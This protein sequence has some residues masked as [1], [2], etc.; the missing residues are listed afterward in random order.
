VNVKVMEGDAPDPKACSLIG[1]CYIYDLPEGL[2]KGAPIEVTYAF[3]TSGRVKV[4]A[5]DVTGGKEA[6]IEIERGGGL[7]EEQ[8]DSYAVLASD[9]KVE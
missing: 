8:I 7:N 3:D 2:P 1:N 9:Y 6:R 5:K 4:T